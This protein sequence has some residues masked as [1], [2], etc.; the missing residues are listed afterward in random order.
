MLNLYVVI[1]AGSFSHHSVDMH[2]LCEY[3]HL[4]DLS[5]FFVALWIN[6]FSM[7]LVPSFLW[8]HTKK[9]QIAKKV[10]NLQ[11]KF[12]GEEAEDAGGVTKEFFLLLIREILN[13]KYGMFKVY[14][15]TQ[16]VWWAEL[17]LAA[18]NEGAVFSSA[19]LRAM[20]ASNHQ[21]TTTPSH[22]VHHV[23]H[24]N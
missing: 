5:V 22:H 7:Y 8:R 16:T 4:Y 24:W 15:E 11:I 23:R 19:L 21:S 13:P 6:S 18:W 20:P 14:E 12:K 9:N 1:Y 2:A 3:Y 10:W 17:L